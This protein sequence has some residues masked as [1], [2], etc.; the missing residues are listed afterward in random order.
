MSVCAEAGER[1]GDPHPGTG[2][3][4]ALLLPPVSLCPRDLLIEADQFAPLPGERR[5]PIT[6][7]PVMFVK[8][9]VG[10]AARADSI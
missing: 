9:T 3:L 6:N 10:Y 2:R 4:G 7:H 8:D 5:C 1:S